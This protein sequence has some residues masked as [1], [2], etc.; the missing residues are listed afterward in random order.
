[1]ADPKK[2]AGAGKKPFWWAAAINSMISSRQTAKAIAA[3]DRLMDQNV[4][5]RHALLYKVRL[6]KRLGRLKEAIA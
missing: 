4:D 6:L 2:P 1:M 5:R 3:L